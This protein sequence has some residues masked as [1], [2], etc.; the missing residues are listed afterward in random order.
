MANRKAQATL[1]S[2]DDLRSAEVA[3]KHHAVVLANIVGRSAAVAPPWLYDRVVQVTDSHV[4]S[5]GLTDEARQA[6]AVARMPTQ[7]TLN[8]WLAACLDG[9][10]SWLPWRSLF[11]VPEGL[12]RDLE[13]YGVVDPDAPNGG[14]YDLEIADPRLP[15]I[16]DEQAAKYVTVVAEFMGKILLTRANSKAPV[17]KSYEAHWGFDAI[18][19]A[20]QSVHD[21]TLDVADVVQM[22]NVKERLLQA[23]KTKVLLE[24]MVESIDE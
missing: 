8:D 13:H 12:E 15:P 6:L 3:A 20:V 22:C 7:S 19:G 14:R 23:W 2:H 11:F 10:L 5:F 21:G 4:D 1:P 18:K 16:T 9:D 24:F 17:I